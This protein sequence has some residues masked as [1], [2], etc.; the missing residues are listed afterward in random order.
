MQEQQ[1]RLLLHVLTTNFQTAS[2]LEVV[3]QLKYISRPDAGDGS[4]CDD[5]DHSRLLSAVGVRL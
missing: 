1:Q 2:E 3:G 5:E 4:Q